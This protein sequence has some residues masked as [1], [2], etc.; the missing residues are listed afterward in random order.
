MAGPTKGPKKV[1]ELLQAKRVTGARRVTWPVLLNGNEIVWVRGLPTPEHLRPKR[2]EKA[3]LVREK[4]V[5]EGPRL[6]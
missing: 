5:S 3:L 2:G 6:V 4:L 1:K